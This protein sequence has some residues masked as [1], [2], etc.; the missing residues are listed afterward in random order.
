MFALAA[1]VVFWVCC[2]LGMM[3]PGII[4]AVICL[5]LSG[6]SSFSTGCDEMYT[7]MIYQKLKKA[8]NG[9]KDN[10]GGKNNR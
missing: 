4:L 8:K 5:V 7:E 10:D 2:R 1:V 6:L 9:G 3:R